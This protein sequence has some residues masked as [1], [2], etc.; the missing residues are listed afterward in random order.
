MTDLEPERSKIH[1]ACNIQYQGKISNKEIA[2]ERRSVNISH[3]LDII[4]SYLSA[5]VSCQAK[6]G[7]SLIDDE[8]GNCL[9]GSLIDDENC[10]YIRVSLID[11]EKG[12]CLRGFFNR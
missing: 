5:F 1:S 2:I 6:T 7:A 12:N 3:P 10:N 9:R 4:R 8:K 11:D